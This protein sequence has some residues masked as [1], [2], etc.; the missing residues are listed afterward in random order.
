MNTLLFLLVGQLLACR[1]ETEDTLQPSEDTGVE[2]T[3]ETAEVEDPIYQLD[4]ALLPQGANPCREPF[5]GEVSEAVDGDTIWVHGPD[6]ADKVRIIGVDT[7][8]LAYYD[9]EVDDCYG[10][11]AQAFTEENLLGELVWLSFDGDCED[12]Y[13]RALAYVTTGEGEQGFFERQLL[14]GGYAETMTFSATSTYA[15][16]FEADEAEA[17]AANAGRWGA[18]E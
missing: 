5:V 17:R 15:D 12:D 16:V 6:G 18:C 2:E 3:G 13:G 8:E 11:E 1:R 9:D 14:R 7:P 4:T 10:P